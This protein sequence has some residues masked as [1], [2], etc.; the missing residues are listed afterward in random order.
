MDMA[1]ETE[2]WLF[3]TDLFFVD[4]NEN[5]NLAI[6]SVL[7]SWSIHEA[8][9][10][11]YGFDPDFVK[12]NFL[13]RNGTFFVREFRER[14][15]L[16][17]RAAETKKLK[18]PCPPASYIAWAATVGIYIKS[19]VVDAVTSNL[20][21]AG[22]NEEEK[23]VNPQLK[24]SLMKMVLGMAVSKYQYKT[25]NNPSAKLIQGDLIKLGLKL[26]IDTIRDL[27]G[28]AAD[29]FISDIEEHT[30]KTV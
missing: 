12:D 27:L 30:S 10:L 24:R 19:D 22:S 1:S 6:W 20:N 4:D 17:E 15:M 9:C 21:T 5:A 8:T 7:P 13:P 3:E 16:A 28:E 2:N 23:S 18:F 26:H 25:G 29:L 14:M 11:S